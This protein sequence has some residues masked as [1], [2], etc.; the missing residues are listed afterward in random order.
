MRVQYRDLW[1][2][3]YVITWHFIFN[4]VRYP[5]TRTGRPS[6]EQSARVL[7]LEHEIYESTHYHHPTPEKHT[8]P[9]RAPLCPVLSKYT[10][11]KSTLSY[12]VYNGTRYS[13]TLNF[14]FNLGETPLFEAWRAGAPEVGDAEVT[15]VPPEAREPAT[16]RCLLRCVSPT[17][18]AGTTCFSDAAVLALSCVS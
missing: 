1:C 14:N 15:A 16:V 5:G 10:V 11:Y 3:P 4:L 12:S 8:T 13:G 2:I 6:S 9:A 7:A 18:G 17:S